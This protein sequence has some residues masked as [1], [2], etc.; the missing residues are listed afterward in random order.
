M[1]QE[2]QVRGSRYEFGS[3]SPEARPV[4]LR[5]SPDG[6]CFNPGK[7]ESTELPLYGRRPSGLATRFGPL[8]LMGHA[9]MGMVL[10]L[11]FYL[12]VV[13]TDP[14]GTAT[15]IKHAGVQGGIISIGSLVLIFGIGAG[16]TGAIFVSMDDR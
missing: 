9:A 1:L 5:Q 13:F 15:L 6:P 3:C 2:R 8:R 12:I 10:S 4:R 14:A 7:V 11:G 16:L